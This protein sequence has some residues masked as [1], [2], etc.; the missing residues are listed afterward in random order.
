MLEVDGGDGEARAVMGPELESEG[1]CF[2]K[3]SD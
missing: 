3:G 1:L 2:V